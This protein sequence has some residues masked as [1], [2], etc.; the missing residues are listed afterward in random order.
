MR[1]EG[2]KDMG[3]RA[4]RGAALIDVIFTVSLVAV[5]SGIAIPSMQAAREVRAARSGARYL[6]ARLQQARTESLKRNA[7]VAVRFDPD[8]LDR[9]AV[10]RDGDGDG[11]LQS[12]I[13]LGIDALITPEARLTDY[14]GSITLR[15][16]HDVSEPETGAPLSAGG[17]PLR[18]GA[19]TLL[20]VQPAWEFDKRHAV[21]G[22]AHR[23]ANGNS[24]LG[25]NRSDAHSSFRRSGGA[26]ARGLT[27]ERERRLAAR[28][29]PEQTP[30][31]SV[32]ILR[33]GQEVHVINVSPGGAL[34]ESASRMKPGTLAPN[35]SSQAWLD[36]AFQVE[37]SAARSRVSIRFVTRVPWSSRGNWHGTSNRG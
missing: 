7:A 30:W 29:T 23:A 18:I 27:N 11:V 1:R 12:D 3:G 36:P 33:P 25:R 20:L 8:D 37:S 10:Y 21:R 24:H 34:M 32:A 26:V 9:F 28:V 14:V 17:N 22:R 5:L 31:H 35:C 2:S 6:A 19:S 13:D 15:I 16:N 4:D